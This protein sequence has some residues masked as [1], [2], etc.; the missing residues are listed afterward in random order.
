MK[1]ILRDLWYNYLMEESGGISTE[2]E[3]RAIALLADTEE[4]LMVT[5]SDE[6]KAMLEKVQNC[7]DD[8]YAISIEKA[9]E[10]GVVFSFAFL[11][12]VWDRK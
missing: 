2:E 9:F 11:S 8:V 10:K 7:L 4:Q 5:M 3:K 6:Q 12:A 1:K